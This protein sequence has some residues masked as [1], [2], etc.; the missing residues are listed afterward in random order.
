M[1]ISAHMGGGIVHRLAQ[2]ESADVNV[3]GEMLQLS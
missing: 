2:G 3:S 1:H